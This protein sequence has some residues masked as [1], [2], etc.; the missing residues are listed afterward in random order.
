VV[1]RVRVKRGKRVVSTLALRCG[2]APTV[3]RWTPKRSAAR[4][5]YVVEV[6]VFSDRKPQMRR[7]TVRVR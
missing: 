1:V 7:F 6:A 2:L 3:A 5:R 4:G